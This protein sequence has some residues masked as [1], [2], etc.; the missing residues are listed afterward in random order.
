MRMSN[1]PQNIADIRSVGVCG[2][3]AAVIFILLFF[4]VRWMQATWPVAAGLPP[5]H[6]VWLK[7]KQTK[8]NQIKDKNICAK[9]LRVKT[10]EPLLFLVFLLLLPLLHVL[11]HS[12]SLSC[13]LLPSLPSELQLFL[14][15]R[16]SLPCWNS[17]CSWKWHLGTERESK[18]LT[19]S[20]WL[21]APCFTGVYQILVLSLST[22]FHHT[23]LW[24]FTTGVY[25]QTSHTTFQFFIFL[26]SLFLNS[27]NLTGIVQQNLKTSIPKGVNT[28]MRHCMITITWTTILVIYLQ[29]CSNPTLQ[30][31][32]LCP[33][34]LSTKVR[35]LEKFVFCG[36]VRAYLV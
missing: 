24:P 12:G 9:F 32:G 6:S 26:E 16:F 30:T 33:H 8:A 17:K 34:N 36:Q 15:E 21:P 27:G 31:W 13:S 29:N 11:L 20:H 14:S 19:T 7:N 5:R 25:T 28:F 35:H 18:P 3:C 2:A 22:F 4:T 10:V 1:I 23:F